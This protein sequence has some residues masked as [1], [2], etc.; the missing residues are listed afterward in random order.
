MI[1]DN[2]QQDTKDLVGIAKQAE[3]VMTL[4]D[5]AVINASR[6]YIMIS[7]SVDDLTSLLKTIIENVGNMEAARVNTLG[8]IENITAVL[9][10]T[11]ASA[12]S[13]NQTSNNQLN[14]VEKLS[15]SASNLNGSSDEL[16]EAINK[17][18]V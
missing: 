1:I 9:E 18:T 11:A 15:K 12:N 4:Q 17:F 6:S 16:V 5:I 14:S 8:A 10:E 7:E 3:G 13:V 2:I